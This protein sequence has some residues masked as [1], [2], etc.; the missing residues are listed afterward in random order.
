MVNKINTGAV[1]RKVKLNSGL[2]ESKHTSPSDCAISA[3]MF[4]GI[5]LENAKLVPNKPIRK[6]R[7]LIEYEK[8]VEVSE[9]SSSPLPLSR[10]RL[11]RERGA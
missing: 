10:S 7:L 2:S 6:M 5:E 3:L 8:S 1:S 11:F 4:C 9:S